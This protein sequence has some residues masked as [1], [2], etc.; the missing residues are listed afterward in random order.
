MNTTIKLRTKRDSDLSN[1]D[2]KCGDKCRFKAIKQSE[3]KVIKIMVALRF[4]TTTTF[5]SNRFYAFDAIRMADKARRNR[6]VNAPAVDAE[7][8]ATTSGEPT[9]ITANQPSG[10]IVYTNR[11]G[12]APRGNRGR[13]NGNAKAPYKGPAQPLPPAGNEASDG[14]QQVFDNIGNTDSAPQADNNSTDKVIPITVHSKNIYAQVIMTDLPSGNLINS[15]TPAATAA[16]VNDDVIMVE[17]NSQGDA[18]AAVPGYTPNRGRG[19]NRAGILRGSARGGRHSFIRSNFDKF[20]H[21]PNRTYSDQR[22]NFRP[23]YLDTSTYVVDSR[24]RDHQ[25]IVSTGNLMPPPAAPTKEIEVPP[26]L[27]PGCFFDTPPWMQSSQPL[28]FPGSTQTQ[29][30]TDGP[31]ANAEQ[32]RQEHSTVHFSTKTPPR[33]TSEDRND[34][35]PLLAAKQRRMSD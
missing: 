34:E 20:S 32:Q 10:R 12:N 1:C 16:A 18:T 8:M 31:E 22:D 35:G 13:G 19:S 23:H 6:N 29:A 14:L 33:R 24:R 4:K 30:S 3:I 11:G 15:N 9:S 5:T 25:E 26:L 28:Y 7:P 21:Q 17:G 2:D 27:P